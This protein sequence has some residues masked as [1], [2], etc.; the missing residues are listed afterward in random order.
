VALRI[1]IFIFVLSLFFVPAGFADDIVWTER[2]LK[3][4]VSKTATAAKK[5]KWEKAIRYG[6]QM[7]SGL[8]A[9]TQPNDAKYITQLKN[10]NIYYEKAGR[11]D[12]VAA[13][14][15]TGYLLSKEHLGLGHTTSLV[16]RNLYYKLLISK[17]Q[18]AKA[19]P[20]VHENLSVMPAGR[21]NSFRKLHYLEQLIHLY[22]LTRNYPEQERVLT[23][24]IQFRKRLLEK[25]DKGHRDTLLLLAQNY[26]LQ[27][28]MAQFSVLTAENG[29]K[30]YC[31]H[32]TLA[33][34]S[35]TP[36]KPKVIRKIR[37]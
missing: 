25:S 12:E 10:I 35:D 8:Q 9:L 34:G 16:S 4:I 19:I 23:D 21:D 26:C 33:P 2:K 32:Q 14:V 6:E 5:K 18:F 27:G 36:A 29:M 24:F 28:K 17:A 22:G 31:R 11:L 7:F 1:T 20:L 13:R 30:Y 3:K 37:K 15:Q